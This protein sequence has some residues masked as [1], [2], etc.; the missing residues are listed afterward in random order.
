MSCVIVQKLFMLSVVVS[1]VA[2]N[3]LY[4]VLGHEMSEGLL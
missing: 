3:Y 1:R 2:L 4:G